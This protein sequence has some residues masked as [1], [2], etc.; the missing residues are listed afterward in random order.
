[1]NE[2][3]VGSSLMRVNNTVTK[4]ELARPCKDDI[5]WVVAR[6]KDELTPN[7]AFAVVMAYGE[8]DPAKYSVEQLA[9]IMLSAELGH[10]TAKKIMNSSDTAGRPKEVYDRAI[11]R[12]PELKSELHS[13]LS[14]G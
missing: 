12:L 8:Q 4:D 14:R 5:E 10:S 3:Q 7:A 6:A 1:M 9:W 2:E 11:V 13:V